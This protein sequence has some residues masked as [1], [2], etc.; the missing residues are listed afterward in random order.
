MH[1]PEARVILGN[2]DTYQHH[3]SQGLI[4][5]PRQLAALDKPADR[6]RKPERQRPTRRKRLFPYRKVEDIEQDIR[7]CEVRIE[8]L[9]HA[10]ASPDLRDG[11]RVRQLKADLVEQE[12][13]LE[14]LLA[15]WDEASELN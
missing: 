9:H 5:D 6:A 2:Y 8:A 15:H 7:A 12:R 14:T 3:V 4:P 1:A 13:E 10:L 11:Q